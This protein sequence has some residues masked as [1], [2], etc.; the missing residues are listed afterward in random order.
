MYPGTIISCIYEDRF[1][2]KFT[3]QSLYSFERKF[4]K[5]LSYMA[6]AP[7]RM[8]VVCNKMLTFLICAVYWNSGTQIFT[9][10]FLTFPTAVSS[11]LISCNFWF[12]K[13]L[14]KS[15]DW[16]KISSCL[17]S[18]LVFTFHLHQHFRSSNATK[19]KINSLVF[20]VNES[21]WYVVLWG[22]RIFCRISY[23]LLL[24]LLKLLNNA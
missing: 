1:T 5:Q 8:H 4:S 20:R 6:R 14:I 11:A 3:L 10:M 15:K 13:P 12:Q 16:P 21:C 7:L 24:L 19:E 18:C 17:I 22:I 9:W 2:F 23:M